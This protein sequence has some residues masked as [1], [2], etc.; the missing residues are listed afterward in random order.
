M[1]L[2]L[3]RHNMTLAG[4]LYLSAAV[5]EV[6]ALPVTAVPRGW[7]IE[8]EFTLQGGKGGGRA[9]VFLEVRASSSS[10]IGRRPDNRG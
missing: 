4:T 2:Q 8:P 7:K 3:M 9:D 5:Q 10:S 6:R 1:P